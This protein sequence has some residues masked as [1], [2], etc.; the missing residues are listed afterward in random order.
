MDACNFVQSSQ[1]YSPLCCLQAYCSKCKDFRVQMKR[2][3]LWRLPP[4]VIIQLKRFQYNQHT[5]RKLRD[6]VVFPI[7]GLDLS[8]FVAS[9]SESPPGTKVPKSSEKPPKKKANKKKK[10]TSKSSNSNGSSPYLEEPEASTTETSSEVPLSSDDGRSEMLY[11]LYGVVHH[12]GALS[13]GHYVASLKSDLDGQWR[14]FN[15][16][17]I[18]EI[19]N[20]DVVDSSAYILFYIRRDVKDARLSDYWDTSAREGSGV[21]EQDM[22]KFLNGQRGSSTAEKCVIS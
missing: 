22:E 19:H 1:S 16:A 2:L 3:S 17:Q 10:E 8:P 14:L 9:D 6:L 4:V 7:E 11:D 18:Y 20:R 12:Q 15:D 13:T 5:R 21:S